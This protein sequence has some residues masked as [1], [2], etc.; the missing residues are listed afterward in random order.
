MSNPC[1]ASQES[2]DSGALHHD[3]PGGL[4]TSHS[5]VSFVSCCL[6]HPGI[7]CTP[8]LPPQKAGD[9]LP[10]LTDHRRDCVLP[11]VAGT[12]GYRRECV[13]SSMAGSY[14][15]LTGVLT[16]GLKEW[17]EPLIGSPDRR[18]LIGDAA[19]TICYLSVWAIDSSFNMTS[20][21]TCYGKGN[22]NCY[23]L[24]QTTN[25][26]A[27]T[28]RPTTGKDFQ[29][30]AQ[31]CDIES[32]LPLTEP[33]Q[34]VLQKQRALFCLAD[35][36]A[37]RPCVNGPGFRECGWNA[38]QKNSEEGGLAQHPPLSARG[39][40]RKPTSLH[41]AEAI[42]AAVD[43]TAIGETYTFDHPPFLQTLCP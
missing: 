26:I 1:R 29:S 35:L 7:S 6:D 18:F 16:C 24:L 28:A 2:K 32:R 9:L 12:T 17:Y 3:H 33:E 14:R 43:S 21:A 13:L 23:K 41:L 42:L 19:R 11:W 22:S 25:Q 34:D 38:G 36:D 8:S 31:P 5:T 40:T 30:P 37:C 20:M 39:T 4:S 15:P 27:S 10:P